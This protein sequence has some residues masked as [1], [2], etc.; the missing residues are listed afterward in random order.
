MGHI[1]NLFRNTDRAYT[2]VNGGAATG[3]KGGN[4]L[5]TPEITKR[6]VNVSPYYDDNHTI[7][8]VSIG[9]TATKVVNEDENE[10]IL[11]EN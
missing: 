10:L 3:M 8:N 4:T 11:I 6:K 1:H 7:E 2:I 9:N 5:L